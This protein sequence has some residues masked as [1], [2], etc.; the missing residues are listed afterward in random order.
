MLRCRVYRVV[1]V[2][3]QTEQ[4]EEPRQQQRSIRNFSRIQS[5]VSWLRK[6]NYIARKLLMEAAENSRDF[7]N[8]GAFG[9]PMKV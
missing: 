6:Q 2:N 5:P 1:H 3:L 8:A 4:C 9:G 7:E